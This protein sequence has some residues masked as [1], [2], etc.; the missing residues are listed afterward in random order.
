LLSLVHREQS[1]LALEARATL[2]SHAP[3]TDVTDILKAFSSL[4]HGIAV[5]SNRTTPPHYDS[6]GTRSLY[7]MLLAI[8]NAEG[9]VLTLDEILVNVDYPPR[10]IML[11]LGKGLK[12]SVPP[13]QKEGSLPQNRVCW[14]QYHREVVFRWH[15]AHSS[16]RDSNRK[17]Y[18]SARDFEGSPE[19]SKTHLKQWQRFYEDMG[20]EINFSRTASFSST[21]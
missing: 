4:F 11:I 14:A 7:D 2:L 1:R 21:Q 13:W 5:L 12:H 8:G 16:D 3:N 10:S 6:A 9:V 19:E 18:C 15:M 17:L 20:C